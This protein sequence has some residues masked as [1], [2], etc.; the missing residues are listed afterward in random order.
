[1]T[2][3]TPL[4]RHE[5]VGN[6]SLAIY[7]YAFKVFA[8]TH[9]E[10]Y[11]AEILQTLTTHY[12]VTEVGE[13]TGG[14][15][16]FVTPPVLDAEIVILRN[17]PFTQET[18]YPPNS[19]FPELAHENALDKLT[20]LCQ[21]LEEASDRSLKLAPSSLFNNL[22]VP[23]V[24]DGFLRWDSLGENLIASL[25][26][27]PT[28]TID[29]TVGRINFGDGAGLI[30]DSRFA[31]DNTNKLLLLGIGATLGAGVADTVKAGV[32]DLN[33][34]GSAGMT[35]IDEHGNQMVFGPS[36]EGPF[37]I[38]DVDVG[39]TY[40]LGGGGFGTLT[41]DTI[42]I[43]INNIFHTQFDLASNIGQRVLT[44]GANAAGTFAQFIGTR[45]T[46]F[47]ADVTHML[48]EDLE[49][50][51]TAGR[52][53]VDETGH[54]HTLGRVL[55]LQAGDSARAAHAGGVVHSFFAG[56][57]MPATTSETDM[58]NQSI[59]AAMLAANGQTLFLRCGGRTAGNANTKRVRIYWGNT[60]VFD[61]TALA[62]NG[63]TWETTVTILR[64]SAVTQK[65]FSAGAFYD[66]EGNTRLFAAFPGE[67][68]SGAVTL[69]ITGTQGTAAA[70][71][72]ILDHVKILWYP[73]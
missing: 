8:D 30:T 68:L 37:K 31:W 38:V 15:V 40:F 7:P 26:A 42:G 64:T 6:G 16:V 49:G 54:V 2:I 69:R 34:A 70:G 55:S 63:D 35:W 48:T 53:F 58:Y 57:T 51:G 66:T 39:A 73:D 71:D 13:D 9:L 52:V 4:N 18:D 22:E 72:L 29:V 3:A 25:F 27:I 62:A 14:N 19:D 10:V 44:V 56:F 23:I 28:G 21:Q 36:A 11:V 20:M 50:A 59:A 24:P 5:Y 45:P 17:V 32:T 41:P 47:P 61:S 65:S 43:F 60:V 33:G 1:M 12:S 46:T 67:T